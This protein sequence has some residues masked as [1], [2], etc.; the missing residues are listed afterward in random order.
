MS[1]KP[2]SKF[3]KLKIITEMATWMVLTKR[4]TLYLISGHDITSG[5]IEPHVGL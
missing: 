1:C 3:S 2:E 4:M 5:E